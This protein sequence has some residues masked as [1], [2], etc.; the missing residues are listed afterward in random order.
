[1]L[2]VGGNFGGTSKSSSVITKLFDNLKTD[3]SELVN[4]GSLND[5]IDSIGKVKSHNTVL[6]MPNV[7]NSVPKQNLSKNIGTCLIVS[8]AIRDDTRDRGD[9][10]SRIFKYQANAV[11]A[12]TYG[13]KFSFELIDALGNTW[14]DTSDI[15][16]LSEDIKRF[17][18]WHK[19]SQ[20]V[21][22]VKDTNTL[23]EF[24]KINKSLSEVIKRDQYRYFGN[25]STRCSHLF[26][27]VRNSDSILVSKRNSPKD[28]I[29]RSDLVE[30]FR[31]KGIIRYYGDNKPSVDTPIQLALYEQFPEINYMIHGHS[32]IKGAN[33]TDTYYSC[34]DIRE[35]QESIEI[36]NQTGESNGYFNLKNHG[37]LIYSDSIN[38]LKNIVKDI[39]FEPL[40]EKRFV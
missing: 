11:I 38:N 9:A 13:E 28:S 40:P 24:L 27:A 16:Q 19:D 5:F 17:V 10:I 14:S 18:E 32:L 20:R 15:K 22:T 3:D 36:I 21:P 23:D 25:M 26:P 31:E 33:T 1:M 37:F 6:W 2:V 30:V 7:S 12:I 34:G 39:V 4:G 35:I 29:S 8:K